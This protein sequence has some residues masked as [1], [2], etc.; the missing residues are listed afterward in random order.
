MQNVTSQ[1]GKNTEN[2]K[3]SQP[4]DIEYVDCFG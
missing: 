4:N 3:L 1:T 2:I